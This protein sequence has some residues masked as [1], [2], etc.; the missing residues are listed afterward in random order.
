MKRFN[1]NSDD[2]DEER[3]AKIVKNFKVSNLGHIFSKTGYP[4]KTDHP[5]FVAV[6]KLFQCTLAIQRSELGLPKTVWFKEPWQ[7]KNDQEEFLLSE[8]QA[9]KV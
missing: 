6:K 7:M 9:K 2:P 1:E 8:H 3:F 5:E 4:N